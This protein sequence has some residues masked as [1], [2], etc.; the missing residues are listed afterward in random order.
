[1]VRL[2]LCTNGET[3]VMPGRYN[4]EK[5]HNYRPYLDRSWFLKRFQWG[6]NDDE[7]VTII[8]HIWTVAGS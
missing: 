3:L 8:D 4:D 2:W 6:S 5:G 1:M 7:K